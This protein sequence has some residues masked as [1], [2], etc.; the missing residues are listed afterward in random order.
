MTTL[1][2]FL[3]AHKLP[4]GNPE[5]RDVTH[6]RIGDKSLNIYGGSYNIPD[7]KL[8]E[9]YDLYHQHVVVKGNK[10]YLTEA[11]R[12]GDDAVL[13]I[14]FDFRYPLTQTERI[15]DFNDILQDLVSYVAITSNE[16]MDTKEA[17][18]LLIMI[19]PAVNVCE[20][21]GY[22]KDGIHLVGNFTMPRHIQ[23]ELR[24]RLMKNND[25]KQI[26]TDIG[27]TNSMDTVYDDGI[28]K[29]S[30]N[31]QLYGSR[32]PAHEAY[33]IIARLDCE[34]D[35]YEYKMVGSIDI[36]TFK[37]A[38]VKYL[39]NK[40]VVEYIDIPKPEPRAK[41]TLTARSGSPQTDETIIFDPCSIFNNE[42]LDNALSS[43]MTPQME[44]LCEF[45]CALSPTYS[46]DYGK[47]YSMGCALKCES[48]NN[49]L[50]WMRFST[51][52]DK[53]N[54]DS[55]ESFYETWERFYTM[56]EANEKCK[57]G[58]LTFAS[59]CEWLKDDN[60][61]KFHELCLK[62]KVEKVFTEPAM[63]IEKLIFMKSDLHQTEIDTLG[64]NIEDYNKDKQ[65]EINDQILA[66]KAEQ[67]AETMKMKCE[68]FDA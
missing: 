68:Y 27:A 21:K 31:T 30:T 65:K 6:T 28:V 45:T 56:E 37:T 32:K 20:A 52:S 42:D 24:N 17:F 54:Y 7:D 59:I 29:G 60:I 44:K 33:E 41:R 36:D 61:D 4:K 22:T 11:Q 25:F 35:E 51:K 3:I 50:V 16:L 1:K 66:L 55:I 53:F 23:L 38:C 18:S 58:G 2:Q 14:D 57:N 15:E 12:N 26:I 19:K 10:E 46:D 62:Y 5:K 67:K 39:N 8:D 49:F 9:F 63:N 48:E 47:W 34:D 64:K 43:I 13:Y 40:N